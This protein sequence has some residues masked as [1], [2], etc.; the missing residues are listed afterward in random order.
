M[1]L[2]N[3][4][5]SSQGSV[6]ATPSAL[7]SGSEPSEWVVGVLMKNGNVGVM[8]GAKRYPCEEYARAAARDRQRDKP[9]MEFVAV[10]A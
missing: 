9:F 1:P 2:A 8:S 6:T 5:K 7:P 4:N 3:E 10:R